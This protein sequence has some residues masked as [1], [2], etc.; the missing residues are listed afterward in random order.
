MTPVRINTRNFSDP[1][2]PIDTCGSSDPNDFIDEDPNNI[3]NPN[4]KGLSAPNDP[5]YLSEPSEL[6]ESD[7][8]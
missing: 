6:K 4:P 7:H 8:Q 1:K 3:S 5:S 2:D